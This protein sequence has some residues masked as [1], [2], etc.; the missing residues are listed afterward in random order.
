MLEKY[1]RS[2]PFTRK[3]DKC[4]FIL[5]VLLVIFSVFVL[6]RFPHQ[7]YYHYHCALMFVLIFSKW[8]YYKKM[9]WHYYMTDFCY[10]ANLM[11]MVFLLMFPK[12]DYLFKTCFLFSN[13]ALAVAI[14]AFRNQMVFHRY[15]NLTSLALHI[16]P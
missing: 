6:G 13:G 4:T 7:L 3:R 2:A 10:A 11:I 8:L 12:N 15:D 16:F 9:G 1:F 5:G 14:A